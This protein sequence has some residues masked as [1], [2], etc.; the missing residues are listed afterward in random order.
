M[1]S[2]QHLQNIIN[3]CAS[4]WM[5]NFEREVIALLNDKQTCVKRSRQS[6]HIRS[7]YS[8]T[9]L[10]GVTKVITKKDSRIMATKDNAITIFRDIHLSTGHKGE[11]KTYKKISEHFANI[12]RH[13][14]GQYI[15]QCERCVEKLRK[16]EV[17]PGIVVKPI[18]V[19][20]LNQRGQIDLVDFQSL[21][22]GNF[23]FV[24]HYQEHLTKYHL[25][26]PLTTKRAGEVARQLL[27]IILDFG[28]P[29]VLQSDNGRKFTAEI[30]RELSTLWP[31]L[32]L[33]NGRP[34]HPQSQGS[35]ERSN[36]TLKDALV[37]WMRDNN[38][39]NWSTGLMFVQWTM[40]TTY[41]EAIRMEPYKALFGV[42]PKIG[43]GTLLPSVFL[44]K[45]RTG[46]DEDE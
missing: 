30:I 41:H 4:I 16:M 28:A 31:V 9:S 24:V 33:V 17:G 1:D 29:H 18:T 19:N 8:V 43:L 35:V 2:E 26:S 10:A 7:K 44:N 11:K 27:K 36:A 37:A 25:L 38:T 5:V 15:K 20:E 23:K 40:D 12:P 21:P 46:I 13:I 6:Y 3:E 32:V 14:V 39:S 45:I 42:K 22:D 34:H